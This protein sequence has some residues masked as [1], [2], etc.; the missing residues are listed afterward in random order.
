MHNL[1]MKKTSFHYFPRDID[2][3]NL[4]ENFLVSAV[5]SILVIRVYLHLTGFPQI[6]NGNVHIAHMLFGGFLMMTALLGTFIFL[7]KEV[8]YIASIVGG[9]GFG[10]FID[11]LGKFITHDNNYFYQPTIALLYVIFVLLYL[12]ARSIEKYFRYRKDE[13]AINALEMTKQAF[14]H[15]LDTEEKKLALKYLQKADKNDPLVDIIRE[16]L[17]SAHVIPADGPNIFHKIR[18]YFRKKYD[19]LIKS[20]RFIYIFVRIFVILSTVNF[21]YAIFSFKSADSLADWGQLVTSAVSGIFVLIGIYEINKNSRK[22]GY[23]M[24]KYAVLVSI[25][26][27]QFFLFLEEQLS[28]IFGLFFSLIILSMLQYVIYQEDVLEND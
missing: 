16:T 22:S 26:L 9:V 21:L 2:A 7:N 20:K 10:T 28:A 15:D 14:M 11:E 4:L 13:Y 8:K 27:T 6:G 18:D 3:S 17:T 24:F 12:G 19:S 5:A 23:E 25:F 1:V